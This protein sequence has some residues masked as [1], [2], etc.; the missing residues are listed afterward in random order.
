MLERIGKSIPR[1]NNRDEQQQTEIPMVF[2]INPRQIE[3]MLKSCMERGIAPSQF[4]NDAMT[5]ELA[6]Q[7]RV[8][9]LQASDTD[10]VVHFPGRDKPPA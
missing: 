9:S 8:K 1:R 7:E 6:Y 2:H 4:F 3:A 5:R 10:G